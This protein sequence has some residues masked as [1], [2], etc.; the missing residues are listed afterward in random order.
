MDKTS[1][2]KSTNGGSSYQTL[3]SWVSGTDFSNNVREFPSVVITGT[4]TSNTRFRFR[5][6]ASA[7]NDQIYIDD[8][9]AAA[10]KN[11]VINNT[12][13]SSLPPIKK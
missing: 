3:V 4:F 6:D 1:L 12:K 7:N 9:L 2:Y 5:C 10:I 8:I 11:A 13:P